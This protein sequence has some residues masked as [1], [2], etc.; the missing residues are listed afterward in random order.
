MMKGG[1]GWGTQR[2]HLQRNSCSSSLGSSGVRRVPSVESTLVHKVRSGVPKIRRPYDQLSLRFGVPRVLSVHFGSLSAIRCPN[3]QVS[4][5]SGVPRV[6]SVEPTLV[7]KVQSCV[8]TISCPYKIVSL[9]S[10]VPTIRCPY[11]LVSLEYH[12]YIQLWFIKYDQVS[13][14]SDRCPYDQVSPRVP[15]VDLTLNHKVQSSGV[16]RVPSVIRCPWSTIGTIN[17]GWKITNVIHMLSFY[18]YL[19][20]LPVHQF[21]KYELTSVYPDIS[22]EVWLCGA[23]MCP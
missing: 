18:V 4:L 10:G 5:W 16:P 19:E 17:F 21:T 13:L 8:P 3:N 2:L 12:Q 14:Q 7:H 20:Y 9:W 1:R 6:P 23:P 22:V 15:S 11:D